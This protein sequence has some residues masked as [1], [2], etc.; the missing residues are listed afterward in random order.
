MIAKGSTFGTLAARKQQSLGMIG[1]GVLQ[2]FFQT[3]EMPA[4]STSQFHDFFLVQG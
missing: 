3:F 4:V 1:L 2:L